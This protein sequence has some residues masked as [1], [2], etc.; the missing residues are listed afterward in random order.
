MIGGF[1]VPDTGSVIING[2]DVT[3]VPPFHRDVNTVFQSYALFPH[4]SVFENVAYPLRI[5]RL[6]TAEIRDRVGAMLERVNLSDKANRYPHELSGGQR[7]RVALGRALINEPAV[8][9]LDEPLSALDAKLRRSMQMELRRMHTELGLTFVCVTHDQ[10]E[11]LVMSDRIAVLESGQ[12]AQIGTPEKVFEAPANRFVADFI[13]GCNFLPVVARPG[14]TLALTDPGQEG[15]GANHA[16]LAVRPTSLR[17]GAAPDPV[18]FSATGRVKDVVYLGSLL[19]VMV[20]LSPQVEAAVEVDRD[21]AREL[22]LHNG[23]LATL[24][25]RRED[26][27][28][29]ERGERGQRVCL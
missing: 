6:R 29:F 25:A 28:L 4:L 3:N 5:R 19:R 21:A 22:S 17:L 2:Q 18:A 20:Q 9:L 8:L 14:G 12:I 10:E 24:W 15:R 27:S 7:Q 26:I 13:G 11:A 1:E 16:T 23:S